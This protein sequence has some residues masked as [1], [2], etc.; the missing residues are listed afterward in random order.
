MSALRQ[1]DAR[2]DGELAP[3]WQSKVTGRSIVL[4]VIL[5]SLCVFIVAPMLMLVYGSVR[6][7]PPGTASSFTLAKYR[8]TFDSE[9]AKMAVET[10]KIAAASTVLALVVGLALGILIVRARIPGWRI[11]NLVV[12]VPA[13]I[14]PFISAIAWTALLSPT[15]GFL[16]HFLQDVGI[17]PINIYSVWG[18]VWVTGV[19]FAPVAYLYLRPA[20]ETFDH[21]LEEASRVFGATRIRSTARILLPLI[22]PAVLSAVLVIFVNAIGVFE[23]VAIL[24]N[25]QNLQ[26][27]PSRLVL[28]T[29]RDPADVNTAAVL[30]V[31]LTAITLIG[32]WI[33][34]RLLRR[35]TSSSIGGHGTKGGALRL[36]RWRYLGFAFCGSYI[37]VSV[38][39]PI[40]ALVVGSLQPYYSP[41]LSAGWTL[42]NYREVLNSPLGRTAI[43]NTV[44][45]ATAAAAVAAVFASI[46]SMFLVRSKFRLNA[47]MD[48]VATL[49]L[50][51]P[52]S[53]F[54]LGMLWMWIAVPLAVYGGRLILFLAYLAMY[55]PYAIRATN[56]AM[57]SIDESIE[58]S[59]RVFGASW[60]RVALR[61]TVPLLV[62]G[63]L[64]AAILVLY[65]S[66]RELSASLLL[67]S[68]G[69]EVMSVVIWQYHGE[70]RFGQLFALS[71]VNIGLVLCLVAIAT[72]LAGGARRP[73]IAW[74]R[75]ERQ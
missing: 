29:T 70:G 64:S 59:A 66:M 2:P 51:V 45:L 31:V 39:L 55:I 65:Y 63:M 52:H 25:E 16:N 41:D 23:V 10:V 68:P 34:R 50:A 19:Y 74:R 44:V 15:T 49:P 27:I 3:G 69:S 56:T 35:Y 22:M 32:L 40:A 42:G 67:Y 38:G 26:V 61:I 75:G 9:F 46:I 7:G 5:L 28:L 62:P 17:G 21:S 4:V 73:S 8:G 1:I 20:L 11:W 14:A 30:G 58:E 53:V 37:L 48:Y 33:N 24:G 13:Y 47:T 57:Q 6:T 54:G 36:G 72:W 18:I 60:L 12:I 43:V 71:V